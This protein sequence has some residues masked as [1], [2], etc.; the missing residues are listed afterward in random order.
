[1]KWEQV[2][3]ERVCT[4]TP[5]RTMYALPKKTQEEK[6]QSSVR[7]V[8]KLGHD[9]EKRRCSQ[10]LGKGVC[11]VFGRGQALRSNDS[12]GS[13]LAGVVVLDLDVFVGLVVHGVEHHRHNSRTV[14]VDRDGREITCKLEVLEEVHQ[15][16]SFLGS[17]IFG[18][19][20]A[21]SHESM[22][23]GEPGQHCVVKAKHVSQSAVHG[24]GAVSVRRVAEA[25]E[26]SHAGRRVRKVEIKTFVFGALQVAQKVFEDLEVRVA[27]VGHELA[28]FVDH[29]GDVGASPAREIVGKRDEGG[30][31]GG[32][33]RGRGWAVLLGKH[34]ARRAGS[35]R[36]VA[37]LHLGSLQQH[38]HG[39][40]LRDKHSAGLGLVLDVHA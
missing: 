31:L 18:V 28:Q 23:F 30:I 19:V 1:M 37:V 35:L 4:N 32:S 22:K 2:C 17:G 9:C 24:V 21:R 11:H 10:R 6:Q 20:G 27:R 39:V 12:L 15:P 16:L 3:A 25:M 40:F 34:G 13:Q 7:I 26:T 8:H 5:P 14:H 36:W 38:V 33:W 29:E